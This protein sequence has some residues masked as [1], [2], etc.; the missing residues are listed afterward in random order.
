MQLVTISKYVSNNI[1]GM[2]DRH[3]MA[4]M[5]AEKYDGL[6]TGAV[7]AEKIWGPGPLSWRAREHEPIKWVWGLCPQ[8]GSRGRAPGVGS[9]GRSPPEAEDILTVKHAIFGLNCM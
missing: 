9:G 4:D 2:T 8:R 7:L 1:D 6:Y 5:F 3:A